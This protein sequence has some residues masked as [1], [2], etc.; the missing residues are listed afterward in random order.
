LQPRYVWS[1]TWRSVGRNQRAPACAM[2]L[3]YQSSGIKITRKDQKP[4][5]ET[6]TFLS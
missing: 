4:S 3:P 5:G 2:F 6:V 1:R